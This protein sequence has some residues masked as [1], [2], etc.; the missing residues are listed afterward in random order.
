MS[1]SLDNHVGVTD[2]PEEAYGKTLR[3]PDTAMAGWYALL[4]GEAPP[5]GISARDAK[6]ELA[7]RLVER[8]HGAEAAAAAAAHFDRVI[9]QRGIPEQV[10]EAPFAATVEG[11]VH[12]PA[13]LGELFGISRSEA[14]RLLGQGAVRVDGE[15]LGAGDVDLAPERLDGAVLQAGRRQFRRLRLR[16]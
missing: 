8:L 16:A 13:L 5:A 12:L 6:H 2:A 7:R 11:T 9:V 14:R 4:L 15:P 10:Q 3:L 1:K